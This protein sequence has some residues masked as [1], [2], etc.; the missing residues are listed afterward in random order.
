M[1]LDD[2]ELLDEMRKKKWRENARWQLNVFAQAQLGD[3]RGRCTLYDVVAVDA[4]DA[5]GDGAMRLAE[6]ATVACK[7]A[8]AIGDGN[9]VRWDDEMSEMS[10]MSE[11]SGPSGPSLSS[12]ATLD[13]STFYPERG[14][15]AVGGAFTF[16]LPCGEGDGASLLLELGLRDGGRRVRAKLLFYGILTLVCR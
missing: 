1:S 3:W 15:M 8:G 12:A 13:D 7:S 6:G 9:V 14:N 2:D 5:D 10:E 16:A 4:S 11:T